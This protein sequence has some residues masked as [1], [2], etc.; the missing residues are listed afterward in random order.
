MVTVEIM[1]VDRREWGEARAE[2]VFARVLVAFADIDQDGVACVKAALEVGGGKG[3]ERGHFRFRL[4][5]Q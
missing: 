5:G 2:D 4:G 1:C 3:I